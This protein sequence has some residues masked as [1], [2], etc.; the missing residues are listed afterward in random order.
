MRIDVHAH[1]NPPWYFAELDQVGAEALWR[2]L[3]FMDDALIDRQII[4]IGAPQ[5]YLSSAA[6]G[7]KL[8]TGL[9]DSFRELLDAAGGRLGAFGC[10]PLPHVPESVAETGRIYDSL[11]FEGVALGCSALGTPLD[12]ERLAPVWSALNE[13]RAVVYLHPG[14]GIAGVTGCAGFHLAPGY[15]SPAEVA[16]AASRLIVTGHLDRY[17]DVTVVLATLGGSIPFLARRFDR[18]LLQD[19]PEAHAALGGSVLPH[20][21][22]FFCDTSVTEEPGMLRAAKEIFGADRIVLGTDYAGPG[23]SCLHAIEYIEDSPF[24]SDEEKKAVLDRNAQS[25]L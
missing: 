19:A 21:R 20:F 10:L 18:G 15:V 24:L 13:C 4:S 7:A 8:A 14:V 23:A 25:F 1:Y 9:N 17:P 2:R 16:V 11:D 12:D 6:D 22:R 3:E 5:P